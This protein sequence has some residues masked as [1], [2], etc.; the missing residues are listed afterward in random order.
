MAEADNKTK[1]MI[2]KLLL[3]V[4]AGILATSFTA[5]A[6]NWQLQ[7]TKTY[8]AGGAWENGKI[9]TFFDLPNFF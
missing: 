7:D 2:K 6:Q 3:I 9:D 8:G 1:T 5:T 4:W